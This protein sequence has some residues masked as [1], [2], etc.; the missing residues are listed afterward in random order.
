MRQIIPKEIV[1]LQDIC[2]PYLYY[3]EGQ[4][5]VFVPDTPLNIIEAK[6]RFQTALSHI[7]HLF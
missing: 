4:G 1:E 7:L 3:V 2:A 5:V 6:K